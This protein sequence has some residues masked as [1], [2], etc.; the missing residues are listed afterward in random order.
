[1]AHTWWMRRRDYVVYYPILFKRRKGIERRKERFRGG[2]WAKPWPKPSPWWTRQGDGLVPQ[3]IRRRE[4]RRPKS[5]E[6]L[7]EIRNWLRGKTKRIREHDMMWVESH[8]VHWSSR[9]IEAKRPPD[10]LKWTMARTIPAK[11]QRDRGC[12]L[13]QKEE[14]GEVV[15]WKENEGNVV[16]WKEEEGKV[17]SMLLI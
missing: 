11:R 5:S 9:N 14:E 17:V 10:L 2:K 4:G 8:E 3:H 13:W 16:S 1:M 12:G 6:D 7:W 15:S